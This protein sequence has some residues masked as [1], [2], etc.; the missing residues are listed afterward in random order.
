MESHT[1]YPGLRPFEVE[2]SHLFFGRDDQIDA[3]LL[4]LRDTRFLAVVGPSGCGK[5]SLV[6][7]GMIA[8]LN[9]GFMVTAGSRWEVAIMR[10]EDRPM[11]ALARA[12]IE[13]TTIGAHETDREIAAGLLGATLRRGPL[14]VVEALQ[15]TPL[16][17]GTNLLL[18]VDQFEEI[19]RFERAG[20]HDEADAFVSLLLATAKQRELPIY[21]VLTMRSDFFGDCAIFEGLPEALNQSQYL[22]PRLTREQRQSAIV[23]PAKVFGGDV[24]P[25]LVNRLLNEMGTDPDQLPLM[26]HLLM[27]MWTWR[28]DPMEIGEPIEDGEALSGGRELTL[29]DYDAVGGL[30]HA[31]SRHADEAFASL[32]ARQQEIAETLFRALSERA[33]GNRDIRHPTPAGEAAKLAGASLEEV[34][35][36]VDA[37]RAPGRSFIVPAL[38]ERIYPERFLDITHESLIRQWERLRQWAE[39]EKGFAEIYRYLAQTASLWRRGESALWQSPDLDRGLDWRARQRPTALWAH[40]YGGDFNLAMEFLAES[41]KARAARQAEA[42]AQRRAQLRRLRIATA[43]AFGLVIILFAAGVLF[44]EAEFAENAHYYKTFVKKFGQPFG[45]DELTSEQVRHRASSLKLVRYGFLNPVVRIEAVDADGKC[46]P[47]ND[48][49]TH[50]Q[51]NEETDNAG[52][53]HECLWEFVYDNNGKVVSEIALDKEGKLRWGY[54]Y[55]PSERQIQTRNAYYVGRDHL[56]AKFKNS[57]AEIVEYSY[58]PEGYEQKERWLDR[59]GKSQPLKDQ[60]YGRSYVYDEKGRVKRM[61]ALDRDG[62]KMNDTAGNSALDITF[63]DVGNSRIFKAL[64]KEDKP[65]MT[66]EPHFCEV[67]SEYDQNGNQTAMSFFDCSGQPM[68]GEEGAHRVELK[69][70]ARGY[71][72]E[73]GYYGEDRKPILNNRGFH[74]EIT[75]KRDALGNNLEWKFVGVAGEPAVDA[76]GIHLYKATYDD[77]GFQTSHAFFDANGRRTIGRG[78]FHKIVWQYN[79]DGNKRGESYFDRDERPTRDSNGWYRVKL[80]YDARGDVKEQA[81]F[82][83]DDRPT[84]TND[85]YHLVR[86]EYDEYGFKKSEAYFGKKVET[87]EIGNRRLGDA[88]TGYHK[89][90][91]SYDLRGNQTGESYYDRDGKMVDGPDGFARVAKEYDTRDNIREWAFYDPD[92]KLNAAQRGYAIERRI[93]DNEDRVTEQSFY[94]INRQRI[95]GRDGY[96]IRRWQY[97]GK[98]KNLRAFDTADRPIAIGGCAIFRQIMD[99]RSGKDVEDD[100]LDAQGQLVGSE[101][102]AAMVRMVYDEHGR[103]IEKK[104]FDRDGRPETRP[105]YFARQRRYDPRGYQIEER[106]LDAE[107]GLKLGP[108]GYAI[109][110]SHYDDHGKEVETAYFGEDGKLKFINRKGFALSQTIYDERGRQTEIAYFGTD[111]KPLIHPKFGYAR[112]TGKYDDD[113]NFTEFALYGMSGELRLGPD[114]FAV[115]RFKYDGEGRQIERAYFGADGK[116]EI[117]PT[118]GYHLRRTQYD[119]NGNEIE[120]AFYDTDGKRLVGPAGY[121]AMRNK[122]DDFGRKTEISFHGAD[123]KLHA[124]QPYGYAAKRMQY[125]ADG[126]LMEEDFLGEDG[127]PQ[128]QAMGF[129]FARL[130]YDRQRR[131]AE[132]GYFGRDHAPTSLGAGF[133]KIRREIVLLDENGALKAR[134]PDRDIHDPEEELPEGCRDLAGRP[135]TTHPIIRWVEPGNIAERLGLRA[136]DVIL[137]YDGAAV[138][139]PKELIDLTAKPG[140]GERRIDI[141]RQGR[142]LSVMAP[143]GKIGVRIQTYLMGADAGTSNKAAGQ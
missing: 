40:R 24:A 131:V 16:P 129:A 20:G 94:D 26:Q 117:H 125:D 53:L 63:D 82:D 31:L 10:P 115:A 69:Y 110:R 74:K 35:A 134:C 27:R 9:A 5:S 76:D 32:D 105:N 44:Y 90:E 126:K 15:D 51:K 98:N 97:D 62:H 127:A 142:S 102:G 21:V 18:L 70:D 99:R 124:P 29:A 22:T 138:A 119:R 58:S 59:D 107:G 7:A 46:T 108:D 132:I 84:L 6:R 23:G 106:Y 80:A 25:D 61:T 91:W 139:T 104:W 33:P 136:G 92:N 121:A 1:P 34:I 50:L 2:E 52:P 122:F 65:I 4:R 77:R 75:L 66:K 11:H 111:S 36:V 42:A 135:L 45:I 118:E 41:E 101:Y 81:N 73:I 128:D 123:G 133:A 137:A 19:F 64:D 87:V 14:G 55:T 8:S 93:Y 143:P 49:G 56:L 78:G 13:Q 89:I 103:E 116:P 100:C 112:A 60:A 140:R 57:K 79:G 17:D 54:S 37:F 95:N 30:A 43:S 141:V 83:A 88:K 47:K 28:S 72:A 114:G 71:R 120:E 85:G 113:G 12:L 48:V 96:A 39:K 38:P 67:K 86:V 109:V 68:P 3:L 130:G